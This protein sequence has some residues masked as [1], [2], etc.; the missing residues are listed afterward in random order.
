MNARKESLI[1]I[2]T[3]ILSP[4]C[5]PQF[6]PTAETSTTRVS[7]QT[8]VA[9]TTQASTA[10]FTPA[11]TP[12]Q[13]LPSPTPIFEV[14][15]DNVATGPGDQL[16]ASGFGIYGDDIR[17]FAEWDGGKWVALGGGLPTSGNTLAVDNTGYLYTAVLTDS[18]EGNTTAIMR[19]DGSEWEDITGN[20]N[21]SVDALMPGRLSSNVPV[22]ALAVDNVDNLYAAGAYFY[23]TADHTAELP[24]GFVAMWDKQTWKVLGQ[25]FDTVNL[26]A[27][28]VSPAG[29]V[30]VSGEQLL[31][32]EGSSSYIAGWDG[33]EWTPLDTGRL[34][35]S[36]H[37]ALDKSGR[38]YAAGQLST[39]GSYIVYW[40]GAQW[41]TIA[42]QLTGDAPAVFDLATDWNDLLYVGGSFDSV[43]GVPARNIA[44]WDGSI[45]RPLGEGVNGQVESIALDPHGGL[46]A[47][48][49]F[50]E[51]G[52][53]P[54]QHIARWDGQ[55]W[56][57][58][59]P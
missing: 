51:A 42:D 23:P 44:Y 58:L 48:G 37:L 8:A 46:Y 3:I 33:E 54:V 2:I 29:K 24:M 1:F 35:P 16:F 45:W 22:A 39:F 27:L 12:S 17:H 20:L 11:K 49:F 21:D 4:A 28:A 41:I 18:Q 9:P 19:W 14:L 30:Y 56:Y 59:E 15:I 43:N 57:A 55:V 5:T 34:T 52:G 32:S 53:L 26:F 25:G 38:L 50:T 13:L 10:F 47:A 31:L 7:T 6:A 36:L 40:D